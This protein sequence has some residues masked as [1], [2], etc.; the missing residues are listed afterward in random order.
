MQQQLR[1]EY[2]ESGDAVSRMRF[3]L[4][5]LGDLA[6]SA[7]AEL[8][9]ELYLDAKHAVR[10]YPNRSVSMALAIMALALAIGASTGVFSVLNALLWRSLPF[11]QPNQLVD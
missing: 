7:P 2:R 4:R 11:A 1:D 8:I 9:R 5:V 6:L 3:W 10:L